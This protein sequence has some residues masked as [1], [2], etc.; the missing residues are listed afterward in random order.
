MR[1]ENFLLLQVGELPQTR[2]EEEFSQ[3]YWRILTL[4]SM[5]TILTQAHSIV[6]HFCHNSP[7][8]CKNEESVY[9]IKSEKK[10]PCLQF[11][12]FIYIF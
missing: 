5:S 7:I 9:Y 12:A 6:L 2:I 11:W 3:F 1:R 4:L 10:R 8:I